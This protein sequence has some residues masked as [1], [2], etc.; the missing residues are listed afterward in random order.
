MALSIDFLLHAILSANV[1]E[2][3]CVMNMKDDEGF[4][5]PR[6]SVQA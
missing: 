3:Y 6:G 5:S 4:R 2:R 1:I